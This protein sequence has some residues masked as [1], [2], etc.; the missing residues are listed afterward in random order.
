MDRTRNAPS[1]NLH[2]VA[3][4]RPQ[5]RTPRWPAGHWLQTKLPELSL[6]PFHAAYSK[7]AVC[8]LAVAAIRLVCRPLVRR[9]CRTAY[10]LHRQTCSFIVAYQPSPPPRRVAAKLAARESKQH[11]RFRFCFVC[12]SLAIDRRVWPVA[13]NFAFI[14]FEMLEIRRAKINCKLVNCSNVLNY[15]GLS[16]IVWNV[17]VTDYVIYIL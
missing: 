13:F 15:S 1:K 7:L 12:R 5:C 16:L 2:L 3:D 8:S 6:F 14:Y 10:H 11:F 17:Q 9:R 4:L